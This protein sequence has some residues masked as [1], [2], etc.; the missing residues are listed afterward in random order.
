MVETITIEAGLLGYGGAV[1]DDTANIGTTC[2]DAVAEVIDADGNAMSAQSTHVAAPDQQIATLHVNNHTQT[3][4]NWQM[5]IAQQP[6]INQYPH[7]FLAI[8]SILPTN[9]SHQLKLLPHQ[10]L[11]Q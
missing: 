4:Q 1:T 8:P 3:D 5:K 10:C 2:C 7:K 6:Y 9:C 11:K